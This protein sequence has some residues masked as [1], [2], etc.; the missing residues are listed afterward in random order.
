MYNT[1]YASEIKMNRAMSC[2]TAR[3]RNMCIHHG[4]LSLLEDV[5]QETHLDTSGWRVCV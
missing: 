5:Y 4:F 1:I 3:S 2:C